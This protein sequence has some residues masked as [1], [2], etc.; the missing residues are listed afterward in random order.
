MNLK[1]RILLSLFLVCSVSA[2][3]QVNH[4]LIDSLLPGKWALTKESD[5]KMIKSG[6]ETF[7]SDTVFF[8][9]GGKYAIPRERHKWNW[10]VESEN[11][12][13]LFDDELFEG[14]E[15]QI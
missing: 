9:D 7:F 14:V 13:L 1:K 11:T 10:S 3:A 15:Y 12:I 4:K 2:I 6:G 8:K 5:Y